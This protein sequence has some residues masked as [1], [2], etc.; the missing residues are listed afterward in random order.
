MHK[1]NDPILLSLMDALDESITELALKINVFL[2]N[3]FNGM[4][5]HHESRQI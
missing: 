5:F 3:L 2:T 4:P 1:L